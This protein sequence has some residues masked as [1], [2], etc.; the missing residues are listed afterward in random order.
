MS[1]TIAISNIPESGELE[2]KYSQNK[3]PPSQVHILHQ[4]RFVTS[5]PIKTMNIFSS[6]SVCTVLQGLGPMSLVK[7]EGCGVT[8]ISVLG[9]DTTME[10]RNDLVVQGIKRERRISFE[11]TFAAYYN[12]SQLCVGEN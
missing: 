1:N 11:E 2:F 12:T 3:I 10:R 7:C 6:E 5:K 4:H 9:Q 8:F